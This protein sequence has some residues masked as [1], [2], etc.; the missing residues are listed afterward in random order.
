MN[1]ATDHVSP[2]DKQADGLTDRQAAL[3]AKLRLAPLGPGVYFMKDGDGNIL[4]IGKA[5]SL[6][7]RLASYFSR[8]TP[9]D[10]KT[11][12]LIKKIV[13]FETIA[14]RTEKE[15][16]I[17]EQNLIKRHRPKY[18]VDLKDDKRYPSLCL[19]RSHPYPHFT[20]VRKTTRRDVSYFGPFSS[21]QGV[22]E[23]LRFVNKMF[24]LRKCKNREF[25]TRQR[26]CLHYQMDACLAPCCRQVSQSAY[27]A[28]IKEVVLFLNGRTPKLIK[29]LRKEMI[30]AADQE[31]FEEA[32]ALR[33]KIFA[34]ERTLEKQLAV[35]PDFADRDVLGLAAGETMT[36]ITVMS[37]RGG[38]LIG[39]RHYGFDEPLVPDTEL[40]EGF[41]RQHY[42]R[43]PS[44]PPEIL[45]PVHL[46]NQSM[47]AAW[48]SQRAER[49]VRLQW[50]QKGQKAGLVKMAGQNAAIE[51]EKRSSQQAA[52]MA[53]ML[54]LRNC[55]RLPRIPQRI[56]C[57]DNSN[58]SGTNPVSGMV[59]FVGAQPFKKDYRKYRLA[60]IAGSDDY[61][62]MAE[63]L[64]R[65]FTSDSA[66]ATLP[67]LLVIDG[68]KGQLSVAMTVLRQLGL[69]HQMHVIGL[70]KKDEQRGETD[71]KVYLP[72]R[73][74]PVA[75]ARS[76][77]ALRLLERVRNEAHRF[78]ITY[79]RRRRTQQAIVSALDTIA[80]IGPKRKHA[81]LTHFGD[82]NQISAASI[83]ELSAVSGM[84][85]SAAERVHQHLASH[86]A[87]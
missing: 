70:A 10:P 67:D 9:P 48:L 14:T 26:P 63:A 1:S 17:L 45:T 69:D 12:A 16:L 6:K 80:G 87:T 24:K 53:V 11:A 73:V 43:I 76:P 50:P 40:I 42:E 32:A 3:R 49:K 86:D 66:P 13:S 7:K 22:K 8:L 58:L 85:R 54:E 29:Q 74:N 15:A 38:Y 59:V 79:Q 2:E 28:I 25:A 62:A 21:A 20:I 31:R 75:M 61:A 30:H 65:R 71:D 36:I 37:V 34:L 55:L 51:L 64:T 46:I 81:L 60:P 41:L 77:Q 18:N 23:T 47:I 5:I 44:I 72:G 35:T 68:G 83:E 27:Q 39:T 52:D 84:T 4:Y 57:F 56:E 19:D 78:V 33:D 82:I